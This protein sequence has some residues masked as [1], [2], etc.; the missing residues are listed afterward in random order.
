MDSSILSSTISL[1]N[2]TK[3]EIQN[4]TNANRKKRKEIYYVECV[5]SI[6]LVF[7]YIDMVRMASVGLFPAVQTENAIFHASYLMGIFFLVVS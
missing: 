4:V 7:C 3:F 2:A 1:V 5:E 6:E